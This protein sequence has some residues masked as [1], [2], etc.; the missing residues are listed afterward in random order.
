MFHLHRNQNASLARVVRC[1]VGLDSLYIL[2]CFVPAKT[3]SMLRILIILCSWSWLL[4]GALGIALCG[5]VTIG[6]SSNTDLY[7]GYRNW[8]HV[9]IDLPIW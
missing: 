8:F 5:L 2:H 4:P 3:P 7:Y 6:Y 9:N 1:C